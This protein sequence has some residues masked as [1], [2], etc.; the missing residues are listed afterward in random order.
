MSE[1]LVH[2]VSRS[3]NTCGSIFHTIEIQVL[4]RACFLYAV[5]LKI[6]TTTFVSARDSKSQ[7]STVAKDLR[8][9]LQLKKQRYNGRQNWIEN[10]LSFYILFTLSNPN[11]RYQL[12]IPQ[13]A[14]MSSPIHPYLLTILLIF[15]QNGGQS[16]EPVSLALLNEF[17]ERSFDAVF[18]SY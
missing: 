13:K 18:A 5:I 11:N 14:K 1:Q 2:D 17:I 4:L 7:K 16:A 12:L 3:F 9:L 8:D 15:L 6:I 10:I